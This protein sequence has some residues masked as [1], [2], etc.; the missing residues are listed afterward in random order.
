MGALRAFR[1][2]GIYARPQH[3]PPVGSRRREEADLHGVRLFP[4][5]N[6]RSCKFR[7]RNAKERRVPLKFGVPALGG[8]SSDP[9]HAS[10]SLRPGSWSP[11]WPA[12]AGTPNLARPFIGRRIFMVCDHFRLLTS[13]ATVHGAQGAHKV[14][15]I[16]S[17]N[18]PWS[19][20]KLCPTWDK[21]WYT[22]GHGWSARL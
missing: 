3:E 10:K 8:R 15:G 1:S 4:P 16:L 5:A 9:Q 20:T 14:R 17:M 13:A 7:P 19:A 18:R 22:A 11:A 21:V 12:K 6:E 2:N